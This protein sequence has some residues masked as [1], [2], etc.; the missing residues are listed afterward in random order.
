MKAA[1]GL[2]PDTKKL[3]DAADAAKNE[4]DAAKKEAD[5]AKDLAE[6]AKKAAEAAEAVSKEALKQASLNRQDAQ[7]A[8]RLAAEAQ[9]N[10]EEAKKNA[11]TAK[12]AVFLAQ[13]PE[14]KS[15]K[16]KQAKKIQVKWQKIESAEGY[17]IQYAQNSK[18]KKAKKAIVKNA[19]TLQKKIAGL[20][21][22]K[23]Y[24]VRVRAYSNLN[25]TK[26]YTDWSKKK[27]VRV[28]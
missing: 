23:K 24:Y 27:T 18:F 22:G 3:Q 28:K 11:E 10:M 7:E 13:K 14:L 15:V 20:K 12:K 19:D 1:A 8:R 17:E 25:G 6:A 4:A 2:I 21:K 5:A 16:S 9:K 26:S